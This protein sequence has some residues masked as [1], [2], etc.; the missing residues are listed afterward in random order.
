MMEKKK[1]LAINFN[2]NVDEYDFWK[3]YFQAWNFN[4]N[5]DERF[6]EFQLDA[7]A[8]LM[9][10]DEYKSPLRGKQREVF[11]D[12]M[13][14][15]GYSFSTGNVYGRVV[16]PLMRANILVKTEDDTKKGEYSINPKLRK[17]RTLIKKKKPCK[18][19]VS[20]NMTIKDETEHDKE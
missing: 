13:N 15:I 12:N 8:V 16:K 9:S 5:R 4:V 14:R 18:V 20:F 10:S 19:S 11:V 7:I 2:I 3:K 17:L 1:D 6:T